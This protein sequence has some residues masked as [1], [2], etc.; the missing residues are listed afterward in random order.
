MQRYARVVTDDPTDKELDYF[1]PAA[2]KSK[3]HVGSRIKVPLR[4]R[5][6]LATVTAIVD[7]TEAPNPRAIA[8]LLSEKP[9]LNPELLRLAR[10]M[11]EYYCCS[12][13]AAIRSTLPQ[14]IRHGS[15]GFKRTRTLQIARRP[16]PVELE[17]L[18][19]RAPR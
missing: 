4:N 18:A 11:S 9:I 7:E 17:Q 15:L 16:D 19:T 1:I 14:V 10:W 12:V 3:V 13:E 2:W 8:Q 5:E 6:V